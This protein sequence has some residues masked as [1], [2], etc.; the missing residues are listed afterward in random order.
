MLDTL[1]F[2]ASCTQVS[3]VSTEC[4]TFSKFIL[5]MD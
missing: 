5:E 4:A 2:V 3:I 1:L